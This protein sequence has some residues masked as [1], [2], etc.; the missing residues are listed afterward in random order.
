MVIFALPWE[1][2]GLQN[3][4]TALARYFHRNSGTLSLFIS[5]IIFHN[6]LKWRACRTNYRS[7][8]ML[9]ADCL[10]WCAVHMGLAAIRPCH[11]PVLQVIQN[12]FSGTVLMYKKQYIKCGV[13]HISSWD[14]AIPRVEHGSYLT[15][16][17][18]VNN[19]CLLSCFYPE[20][21]QSTLQP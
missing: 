9:N 18:G 4:C 10:S 19:K 3:P 5:L 7:D 12:A 8:Y 20:G 14:V 16:K 1:T 21:S 13:C 11:G 6:I 15:V 2:S 17:N